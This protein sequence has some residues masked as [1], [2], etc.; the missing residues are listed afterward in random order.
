MK[1]NPTKYV[2]VRFTEHPVRKFNGKPDKCFFI[3]YRIDG[4]VKEESAGWSRQGMN[5]VKASQKLAE[6]KSNQRTGEGERTLLAKRKTVKEKEEKIKAKIKKDKAENITFYEIFFDKYFSH[7][8]LN[9]KK[10]SF[11]REKSLFKKWI[12]PVI[13]EIPL[14]DI[15]PFHIEKVKKDMK[16]SGQSPR[17]IQYA[18]AV[19][20][21]VFNWSYK[22]NYYNG[23]NPVLKVE[24][25]KLSNKRVRFLSVEEADEL[26]IIL[27]AN[28]QV[29]WEHALI[30]LHCGLRSGE[31]FGLT[32]A[33][34]DIK[35]E[36]I[37]V[38]DTKSSK[39]RTVYMTSAVKE[40]FANKKQGKKGA[41]V[42]T[43][44]DGGK[45]NEASGVYKRVVE[46]LGFNKDIEDRR[47][48]VV[49]HTLRHTFA[50]WLVQEGEHLYVV[51]KLLGHSTIA[52]TER[53]SHLAPEN[54]K[55]SAKTIEN[56]LKKHPAKVI[57][58][59]K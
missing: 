20:R 47:H 1:K 44:P 25:P 53:Y 13:G 56:K 21:Q 27:K 48:K 41:L 57:P 32:W 52:M 51:Q 5:A 30:S 39:D 8:Q 43:N 18:L 19:I 58:I 24:K 26:M 28:S 54:T 29:V 37:T 36:M 22:N 31:I 46:E 38:L 15:V 17:S 3:R 14:K 23:D 6:L 12:G 45:V 10:T 34:I 7:A 40:M 35:N 2:G 16:L 4:K 59:Q 9:K 42:F 55:R 49:F 11:N 50:S 33:D